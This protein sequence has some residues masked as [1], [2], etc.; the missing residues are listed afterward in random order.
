MIR[1]YFLVALRNL[2][3][4]KFFSAINIVGLAIS[5]S[6]CLGIIM[7]VADQI[8]YDRYNV[9]RDRIFRVTTKYLNTDG[10][11]TG[12]DYSTSPLPLAPTLKNEFTGVEKAARIRRGFGNGWI[13]FERDYSI[14]V[15]GFF[16]DPE[17]LDIFQYDLK[18]GDPATAL[19]EPYSVVLTE[20]A[21]EKLFRDGNPVG[22]IIKVGK[23]GDYRVTGVIR[24]HGEKSH[25]VFEALASFSS[26]KS[27]E[28]K[29]VFEKG[30]LEWGNFTS[31]WV[32]LMLNE[33]GDIASIQSHLDKIAKE[34]RPHKY[35][36]TEDRSYRFSL[37]NLCAITPGPFINNPIGP[38]M[39]RLFVYFFGG[40]ALI[41][42][43]TSCF[44]Y[45]NLSIARSLTR[46]KEIGVRKVN[47]ASRFHIFFQFLAESIVLS[48]L[49]LLLSFILLLVVKPFL[50]NLKFAQ[51]LRWDLEANYFVYG[52]FF[53]F[54]VAVG[55][56][57]GFFPSVVLS[58]FEPIKVLRKAGGIKLFSRLSLRKALLIGQ[59]ALSLVF[60]ISVI[61]LYNQL[62]LFVKAD[63]GFDMSDK[64]VVKLNSTS[65][66]P[67]QQ[68][69]NSHSY[70]INT[71]AAS[72]IPATGMTFGQ[73]FKRDLA[74]TEVTVIDYFNVDENYLDNMSIDLVAGKN[75]DAAAGE[76]N[77]RFLVVN[78]QA[79]KKLNFGNPHDA[80]DKL[81]YNADDSAQYQIIGVVK[82]YNHKVLIQEVAPMALK[83][84]PDGFSIVQV[85]YSG[86]P[87]AAAEVIESA[88]A[89]VNPNQ[90]IDYK[91]FD[92][93][94]KGFYKT[95]FSDLVSIVG[96]I[97][98]M[99]IAISCLGLLGMATYTTETR[100]KEISIRKVL[101]SSD[102]SLIILLSRSFLILLLIAILIAVPV[103]WFLN[104]LWLD[105]I[106]YK[107]ALSAG[108]IF[109][110]VG[111]LLLLGM[112]T[113]GSQTLKAAFSNPV[114]ALKND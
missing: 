3:K 23:L 106:A 78:E 90:K 69:L 34:H 67:L 84:D 72:H 77:K 71:S 62:N 87:D 76:S 56:F 5:M 54:S 19:T 37:Q 6:I 85:K 95:V 112:V 74:D 4:H 80:V 14:P 52:I 18:H 103:A 104:N 11:P 61:L 53:L 75:F 57:A 55:V 7:L 22:Q 46:A 38:F 39:P 81:I 35:L 68:E 8:S 36:G 89:K 30:H 26:L 64:Y 41:V 44:N 10:V 45:T 33:G 58:R 93:E 66:A 88:W 79:V 105:L 9:N 98:F 65:L 1:N 48:F 111:V 13:E 17:V 27:L 110:G 102:G 94:V 70:I 31:G 12:N 59:F 42:M 86:P 60:I 99:A 97:S 15:A 107:T 2:R 32:Y 29:G 101:G 63:H 100:R 28:E 114:T 47:G 51:I 96:V 91:P 83:Y 73:A 40:L 82:N 16:A 92:E 21:A 113:I 43:L 24:D 50:M 20:K 49:A 109:S 108:V 25:I